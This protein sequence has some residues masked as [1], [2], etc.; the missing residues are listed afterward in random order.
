[1]AVTSKYSKTAASNLEELL[2]GR[3]ERFLVP[4]FQR[5][6][7][8]TKDMAGELWSDLINGFK[9]VRDEKIETQDGQYLLGPI[10]LVPDKGNDYRII[11]GQQRLSTI[12]MIFCVARDIMLENT[13]K[14]PEGYDKIME[15]I[16]NTNLRGEHTNWKLILNDTDKALFEEI[17]AYEYNT[18]PAN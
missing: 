8:W 5:N 4:Q 15:M 9:L 14:K 11:D 17:Q 6:Y 16:E 2:N 7:A 18:T 3:D 1:M 10:V 13:E 12:T